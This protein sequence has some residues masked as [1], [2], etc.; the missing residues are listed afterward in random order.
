MFDIRVLHDVCIEK[1][2]KLKFLG[3]DAQRKTELNIASHEVGQL[4][5]ID[6]TSHLYRDR[7]ELI[8][9]SQSLAAEHA[10][11]FCGF[12]AINLDF[13]DSIG[14]REAGD[15][16][17]HL[18]AIQAIITQQTAG[19]TEPWVLFVTSRCNR[20]SVKQSVRA[21]LAKLVLNN[22]ESYN[23]FKQMI[24]DEPFSLDHHKI[25]DEISAK[26]TL[27]EHG[28][29]YTLAIGF[30]KWLI[31]LSQRA[32]DV[33]QDLAA[34]YRILNHANT[35]DMLSLAFRFE[36]I[37]PHVDDP[38]GLVPPRKDVE[39]PTGLSEEEMA[40]MVLQQYKQMI[41]VDILLHQNEI[42]RE[43]MISENA[44]LMARA[45]FDP[46]EVKAWGRENCWKPS[47]S[48]LDIS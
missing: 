21:V 47:P 41:D 1:N 37:Q 6:K 48:S 25:V 4:P 23:S 39:P 29:L 12:D 20:Q 7:I 43:K 19:R 2:V 30:S 35:P 13:C 22:A 15:Y 38:S 40:L 17:T 32:W 24:L 36:R 5:N 45:R 46:E 14:G 16:D 34:G 11:D 33:K 27:D 3:F 10:S 18:E 28:H 44:E 8:A 42:L 9:K 31:Q 26:Q